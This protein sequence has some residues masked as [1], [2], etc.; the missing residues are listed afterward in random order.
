[1]GVSV[2]KRL[3][4]EIEKEA[5]K[6][7]KHDVVRKEIGLEQLEG[8]R[9][10]RRELVWGPPVQ[11]NFVRGTASPTPESDAK[12]KKTFLQESNMLFQH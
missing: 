12:S 11:E 10:A 1:M 3:G 2:Q 6:M 8:D 4:T 7:H 9:D 5:L